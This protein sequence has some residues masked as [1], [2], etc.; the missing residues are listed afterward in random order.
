MTGKHTDPAWLRLLDRTYAVVLYLYP[1]EHRR[2]YGPWIRQAVRDR[3][4]EVVRG[5]R[6]LPR[7]L[8]ELPVDFLGTL[9]EE[10]TMS[11]TGFSNRRVLAWVGALGLTL[12]CVL[13]AHRA[14]DWYY[15][16]FNPRMVAFQEEEALQTKRKAQMEGFIAFL[17]QQR[18]AR[19]QA[20]ALWLDPNRDSWIPEEAAP[21]IAL[22]ERRYADAINAVLDRDADAV[23]LAALAG[24]CREERGCQYDRLLDQLVAK[25]GN[26]AFVWM[27]SLGRA[28]KELDEDRQARAWRML[29]TAGR[30]Q[31]PRWAMMQELVRQRRD[32]G[33]VDAGLDAALFDQTR[34]FYNVGGSRA[35][36]DQC[37]PDRPATPLGRAADCRRVATMLADSREALATVLAA[38]LEYRLAS[39]ETER[40]SATEHYRQARWRWNHAI[41][42]GEMRTEEYLLRHGSDWL[43]CWGEASSDAGAVS[44]WLAV[45][46]AANSAPADFRLDAR[47][48]ALL[49]GTP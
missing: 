42:T 34:W 40:L 16:H 1:A 21:E 14:G 35:L 22:R 36:L 37:T 5:E 18:T 9:W 19:A 31:S 44:A 47:S 8:M 15:R 29:A 48:L 17:Q 7:L 41:T 39:D 23:S 4:R 38:K 20:L 43:R 45:L 3:A 46:G 2:E 28:T 24:V 26:N 33:A 6:S 27:L 30:Y 32:F 49:A 13:N 10:H 11:F 12:A 25:D